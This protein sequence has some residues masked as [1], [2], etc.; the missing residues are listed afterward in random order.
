MSNID[1]YYASSV[2]KEMQRVTNE[3]TPKASPLDTTRGSIKTKT[4]K[5]TQTKSKSNKK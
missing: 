2:L 4:N 1:T 5:A 3:K